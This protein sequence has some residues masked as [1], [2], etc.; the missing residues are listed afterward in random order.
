MKKTTHRLLALLCFIAFSV[1]LHAQQKKTV[2]GVVRDNNGGGL[3]GATVTEKG[4]SNRVLS[5]QNG[6]YSIKVSPQATLTISYIGFT[7]QEVPVNNQET[8][9]VA[10]EASGNAMNEIVV[11]GFGMRKQARKVTYSIQT[12]DGDELARANT[13]NLVN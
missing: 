5:D 9:S 2:T 13:P 1:V 3:A 4:T 12:V 7:T 11:T 8:V 10:L 6:N